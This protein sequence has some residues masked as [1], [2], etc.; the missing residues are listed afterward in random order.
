LLEEKGYIKKKPINKSVNKS[1]EDSQPG[2]AFKF[3]CHRC[4]KIG[5]KAIDCPK[6]EQNLKNVVS[7][8]KAATCEDISF[9]SSI[10][11][12]SNSAGNIWGDDA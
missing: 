2:N 4:H 3:K 11:G 8:E 5:H 12:T 9:L 6:N 7:K 1:I 10:A